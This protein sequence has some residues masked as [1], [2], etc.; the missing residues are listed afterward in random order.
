MNH[1]QDDVLD[2]A[3]CWRLLGTETMGRLA[4]ATDRGVRIWPVN[5]RSRG[6]SLIFRSDP[7][8]KV[9][10]IAANARVSFEIDGEDG[11]ERWSVVV[12]GRAEVIDRD[13]PGPQT[14][15]GELVTEAPGRKRLMIRI[16]PTTV[17][18]RR[19]NSTTERSSIWSGRPIAWRSPS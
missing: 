18:G 13:E 4:T 1:T 6:D 3:E 19:F 5:Y 8:S 17:S 11:D 16:S 10:D 2:T 12:T 15:H 7:G 14:P 9:W